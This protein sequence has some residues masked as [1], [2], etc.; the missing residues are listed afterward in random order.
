MAVEVPPQALVPAGVLDDPVQG[1]V[2][3]VVSDR[4]KAIYLRD[5]RAFIRELHALLGVEPQDAT[6]DDLLRW[7][8][9]L[10]NREDRL[11]RRLK[12][13]TVNRH[14][15]AVK[16]FYREGVRR[17]HFSH[18]PA[19]G[20]PSLRVSKE[21]QGRALTATEARRLVTACPVSGSLLDLRDRLVVMFL[22]LTGCRV[23]ELCVLTLEHFT[24]DGGRR[25]V[26]FHRKRDKVDWQIVAPD[27][28]MLIEVWQHRTGIVEG[29]LVRAVVPTAGGG[30]I[31]REGAVGRR[32][33]H[34]V[35][36]T[37][38]AAAGLGDDVGPHDLRKTYISACAALGVDMVR[39]ARAAGHEDITTTQRYIHQHDMHTNHPS[40]RVADWLTGANDDGEGEE[41]QEGGPAEEADEGGPQEP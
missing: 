15:S 22:L 11:G 18:D 32:T 3:N 17:G 6:Y 41:E 30:R 19:E 25:L 20:V 34:K 10:R 21:P 29:P 24:L 9:H 1:A 12:P 31:V 5:I 16:R 39:I 13:A 8:S 37:R 35:V 26:E 38:S 40:D 7:W 36:K 4:T 27:L 23:T 14:L 28:S 2:A 33:V